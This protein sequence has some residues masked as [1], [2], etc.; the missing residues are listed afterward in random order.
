M[1]IKNGT[2]YCINH[3]ELAMTRNRG[4]NAITTFE[5]VG[6]GFI[7]NSA[8]GMPVVA[9]YCNECGYIETYAAQKTQ[10]WSEI[11][12]SVDPMASYRLFESTVRNALESL[13]GAK[14]IES[15]VAVSHEGQRAEIDLLMRT[16]GATYVFEIKSN[17]SR[18]SIEAAVKQVR[19]AVLLLER[20]LVP[21]LPVIPVVVVPSGGGREQEVDGVTVLQFDLRALRFE[22][23]TLFGE[24]AA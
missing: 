5:R 7:F 12:E 2:V 21:A 20:S 24:L 10:F 11:A 18:Y 9:Y 4:F 8:T 16:P 19:R 13:R 14:S 23:A 22:D 1:P 3:P 15:N 6:G 17:P